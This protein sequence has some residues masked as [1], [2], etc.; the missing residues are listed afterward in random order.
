MNMLIAELQGLSAD[1]RSWAVVALM[2][3]VAGI[4]VVHMVLCPYVRGNR[5]I[6]DDEVEAA[7]N[8]VFTPGARFGVMM[9]LGAGLTLTGLFMIANGVKPLLALAAVVVGVVIIQTEPTRL[10]IR[11]NTQRVIAL[12]DAAAETLAGARDRLKA[13]HFQL[14]AT[15]V[16]LVLALSAGLLAL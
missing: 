10:Q 1:W 11:E 4:S 5:Q 13:S 3:I 2:A 12:R 7:K 14:A 6:P 8:T 15:N 9:V 16:A